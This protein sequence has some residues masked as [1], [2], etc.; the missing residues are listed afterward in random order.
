MTDFRF[1][2][3][4]MRRPVD[5]TPVWL[6]RQAGR[7]LP[8]YRALRE[9]TPNFMEFCRTPEL[10]AQATLQPLARY[11]LDAAILFSDI[12]VVPAAMGMSVQ[13]VK[14]DGPHFPQ[15]LRSPQEIQR[16]RT[17]PPVID[18]LNYVLATI[19]LI[20]RNLPRPL[21][22]IGFAGSPWTC[23][24]YMV[25]GGSSKNFDIIKAL[26]YR[27]PAVLHEL[28]QRITQTTIAYL[29]AQIAAGV[30]AV[31]VFDTWGGVLSHANYPQFSLHYLRQ[32]ADGLTRHGN[33][34]PV[35]LIF[36]TKGG[37]QWLELMAASGC[38]ALGLDWTT[39]IKSARAR[40]GGQV[41]LQGNLDPC[42]LLAEPE[43]IQR[44]VETIC[45]DYGPGSGHIFN[46]G[47]GV[48]PQTPP[49]NVQVMIDAVHRF[50]STTAKIEP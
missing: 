11:D 40:V 21:P 31:M 17:G 23:A 1:I 45:A 16:L 2:N 29:N 44:A 32:I 8:E 30:Q 15:P 38:D 43:Q 3:A 10:A 14:G 28:L 27:E 46:L 50:T 12:L 36:F 48:L 13:F 5:K 22:L 9:Q 26:L 19:Q 35:P 37:G 34:H 47:H 24:T 39:S 41:A 33:G 49:E 20:Q 4:L 7:Y 42:L 18:D 25:E 6:M